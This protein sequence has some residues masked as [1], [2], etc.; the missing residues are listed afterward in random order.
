MNNLIP[1]LKNELVPHQGEYPKYFTP[2]E[3]FKILKV[4]EEKVI[5]AK[6]KK[7]K[8][9]KTNADKN[10]LL[11]KTLW[12]TGARISELVGNGSAPGLRV[13]DID[14]YGKTVTLQALKQK[15]RKTKPGPMGKNEI[16]YVVRRIPLQDGLRGDLA[17]YIAAYH[18]EEEDKIF[19][20]SSRRAREIVEKICIEAGINRVKSHPH[21]FRHSFAIY[22]LLNRVPLP[23]VQKWLGHSSILNT[24]I[25][26]EMIAGD[27]REFYDRIDWELNSYG[28]DNLSVQNW[29]E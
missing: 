29:R 2:G 8:R 16:P 24:R 15:K 28:P 7:N 12:Q 11:I 3:I 13:K 10:L 18:R 5:A 22:C 17:L 20:I 27:V 23:T 6:D 14:M 26:M 25:Y 19:P 21:A 9:E 4:A 1:L